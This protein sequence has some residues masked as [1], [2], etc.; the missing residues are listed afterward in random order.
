MM[1]L[2]IC[3]VSYRCAMQHRDA[4]ALRQGIML[5]CG[6]ICWAAPAGTLRA[7]RHMLKIKAFPVG[8][9]MLSSS[10]IIRGDRNIGPERQ[11]QRRRFPMQYKAGRGLLL[12]VAVVFFATS[13]MAAQYAALVMDARDGTVLH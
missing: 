10:Q 13:A 4:A 12:A 6:I 5:R 7:A 2:L 8:D 3:A 11:F 1:V 9:V